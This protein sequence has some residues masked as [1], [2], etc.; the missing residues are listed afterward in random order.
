M[1]DNAIAGQTDAAIRVALNGLSTRQRVISNN[2]AN[3]DTPGFKAS[4]VSFEEQLQKAVAKDQQDAV[5]LAATNP[6]HIAD[7]AS[8]D[9]LEPAIVQAGN[10]A[11]RNDGNSVDVEAEMVELANTAISYNTLV[12]ITTSRLSLE[13]YVINDGRR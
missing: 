13:R 6:K 11:M 2:L 8:L 4:G 10:T 5:R 12:Q 7:T 3:V 1:G 9:T